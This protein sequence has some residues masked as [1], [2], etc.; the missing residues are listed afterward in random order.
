MRAT[1]TVDGATAGVNGVCVYLKGA[2]NNGQGTTLVGSHDGRCLQLAEMVDAYTVTKG[3]AAGFAS[4]SFKVT[5]T[6]GLVLTATATDD[7]GSPI[8]VVVERPDLHQSDIQDQREAL[9]VGCS[10]EGWLSSHP[11]PFPRTPVVV[12]DGF[13]QDS[14]TKPQPSR[15][16]SSATAVSRAMAASFARP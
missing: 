9:I 10:T 6:G 7:N 8:G 13:T 2:N 12:A 4:F 15:E 5:K 16:P 14:R 3:S 1:T 11:S